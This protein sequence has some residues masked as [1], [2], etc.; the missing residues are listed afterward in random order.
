[1]RLADRADT[2]A[3]NVHADNAAAIAVYT[4][5]GFEPVAEYDELALVRR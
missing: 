5:L 1:V 2:I 4:A 3:L